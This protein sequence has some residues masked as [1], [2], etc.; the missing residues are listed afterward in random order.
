M[1]KYHPL[2]VRHPANREYRNRNFL[3]DAPSQ[4]TQVHS[5]SRARADAAR[6]TAE[7]D[8]APRST[9]R[10]AKPVAPW[11]SPVSGAGVPAPRERSGS[12]LGGFLRSLFILV[13]ILV[14]V[15]TQTNLLDDLI[16]QLRV[17]A[18]DLGLRGF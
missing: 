7:T 10:S 1:S 15:G 6:A 3:L 12:G 14:I 13:V 4:T 8:P 2:D 18:Y 9:R 5:R 16:F 11:G 17:W